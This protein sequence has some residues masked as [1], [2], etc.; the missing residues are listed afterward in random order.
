MACE[1]VPW[2]GL[3][4]IQLEARSQSMQPTFQQ[5]TI[6][7]LC[8]A[9]FALVLLVSQHTGFRKDVEAPRHIPHKSPEFRWM[10]IAP[11]K[12][13]VWHPCY[14]EYDCARLD[15]PLDWQDP[16]DD[17]RA[18]IAMI[19]LNATDRSD[20]KGSLFINPGGPGGSGVWYV[21]NL[22]E[23]YQTI[24]GRNYDIIGFDP[25]GVGMTRPLIDCWNGN[26]QNA[27]LWALSRPAVIDAHPGMLYDAYAQAS[28]WSRQCTSNLGGGP[29]VGMEDAAERRVQEAGPARFVGTASVAR[30]MLEMMEKVGEDKLKFWGFSYGTVL[31]SMFSTLFP[32]RVGRIVSDGN[33]DI[34]GWMMG[35]AVHFLDDAH[36]IMS[37][38]YSLCHHAGPSGCKFYDKTPEAIEA[39][40]QN[41]LSAIKKNPVIIPAQ[42][43]SSNRPEVV[44]FSSVRRLIS[45][46]FYRP[47]WIF[48]QLAEALAALEDGDGVPFIKAQG[49]SKDPISCGPGSD[50]KDELSE[51]TSDAFPAIMCS[52]ANPLL[53]TADEFQEYVDTL[54]GI[55]PSIGAVMAQDFRLQCAGWTVRSKWNFTG[56]FTGSPAYPILFVT[57]S[58]D[59]V[60]PLSSARLNAA[61]FNGSRILI[62]DSYGHTSLAAPSKCK[63]AVVNSYFQNGTLPENE[64]VCKAD[65]QPFD[66]VEVGKEGADEVDLALYSLMDRYGS[67]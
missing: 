37:A 17:L 31:A 28:A 62:Q 57:N 20:Y 10:E 35:S 30:D 25:R 54:T 40:L 5:W 60:T 42:N 2:K 21:K 43:S 19:R 52:E 47:I 45:K 61:G 58:A 4:G 3:P 8:L 48:P 36:K 59:N 15:V 29:R 38:F 9:S 18:S 67:W 65:I 6:R 50:S 24:A 55:S 34:R 11:K 51:G 56:P 53:D 66:R 12:H 41:L 1:K 7:T 27:E 32:D 13:I 46:S 26:Q 16:S 22:G 44:S 49:V 64:F 39:R 23:L 14:E 63:A 33:V